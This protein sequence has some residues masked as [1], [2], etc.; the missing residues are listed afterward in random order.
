MQVQWTRQALFD[1]ERVCLFLAHYDR[2][3][4]I[5]LAARLD[6]AS[7][8]LLVNP[9]LGERVES[10]VIKDVRKLSVG[11]YVMHYEVA[12]DDILIL[13]VWHAR[14]ERG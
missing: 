2:D 5:S 10:Y 12:D 6:N 1:V 13:R 9:R 4:A 8:R 3:A 7:A 11:H 14:E